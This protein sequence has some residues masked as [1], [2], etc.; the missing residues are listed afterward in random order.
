MA[1][2]AGDTFNVER[3]AAQLARGSMTQKP[4]GSFVPSVAFELSRLEGAEKCAT[5]SL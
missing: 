3:A 2:L 1:G 4:I 5:G